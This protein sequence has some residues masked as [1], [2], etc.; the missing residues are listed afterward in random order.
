MATG[1]RGLVAADGGGVTDVLVVT[2]TVGMLNGVLGNT[3]DLGPAVALDGVLVVGTASLE[4]GLVDTSTT[5]DDTDGS[6]A[7]G[8]KD[9]L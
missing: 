4:E 3:T 8:V 5:G 7:S 2:T 1:T 6:S 9:L